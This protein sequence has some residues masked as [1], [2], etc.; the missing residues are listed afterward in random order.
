MRKVYTSHFKILNSDCY[1]CYPMF[2]RELLKIFHV[3]AIPSPYWA[4][5]RRVANFIARNKSRIN[6]DRIWPKPSYRANLIRATP[7]Q[8]ERHQ[9]RPRNTARN[10]QIIN[11]SVCLRPT[12]IWPFRVWRRSKNCIACQPHA[13]L[14]EEQLPFSP[15]LGTFLRL[16]EKRP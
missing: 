1:Q 11:S 7:K 9:Q 13:K 12:K 16:C 3:E 14:I 4:R 6:L 8:I 5:R 10:A 2:F 15:P